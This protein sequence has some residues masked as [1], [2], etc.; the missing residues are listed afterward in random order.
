MRG[1]GE[2]SSPPSFL[3]GHDLFHVDV[4]G[5]EDLFQRMKLVGSFI[6]DTRDTGIHEDLEAVDAWGVGNV[7]G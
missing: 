1:G 3:W 2:K 5:A 6:V 7:N 4:G